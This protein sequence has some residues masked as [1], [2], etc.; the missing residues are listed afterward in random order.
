MESETLAQLLL[1]KAEAD[2]E[3]ERRRRAEAKEEYDFAQ[4]RYDNA[5]EAVTY[6]Q[7]IVRL[8]KQA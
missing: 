4:E 8:E 2:V 5:Q 1:K 7:R 6:W 3:R